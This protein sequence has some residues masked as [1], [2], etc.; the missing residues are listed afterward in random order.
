MKNNLI[1]INV[2]E[3]IPT[4]CYVALNPEFRIKLFT[5]AINRLSRKS[6]S[7]ILNVHETIIY[8][9]KIGKTKPPLDKVFRCA[10]LLNINKNEI[11]ENIL[12][13]TSGYK[14]FV[15]LND[16]KLILDEKFAEWLG[17]LVGDGCVIEKYIECDNS[18]IDVIFFFADYLKKV[19]KISKNQMKIS[20]LVPS[21]K[22]KGDGEAFQMIFKKKG[23]T[24]ILIYTPQ[25]SKLR[26]F[27]MRL[28]VSNKTLAGILFNLLP[29]LYGLISE[30][31]I[32]V[33]TAYIRGFA[34]AEGG[35][36]LSGSARKIFICQKDPKELDFVKTLLQ[37]IGIDH[38]SNPKK[39]ERAYSIFISTRKEIE[40][41]KTLIGF[42]SNK[43][44]NEK[45]SNVI[46]SYHSE[47]SYY[48]SK[49]I[50][51]E[52]IL[53]LIRREKKITA[54]TI[55]S[56]SNIS[57]KRVNELLNEMLNKNLILVSKSPKPF[58]YSLS[59]DRKLHKI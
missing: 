6:L 14:G 24:N 21:N 15:S 54:K 26:K 44:K 28:R 31:P 59:K 11:R 16:W 48:I 53:E 17:L 46:D 7:Q 20:I 10:E 2:I 25:N 39:G 47:I 19:F 42:G 50:R 56:S 9:W 52:E 4:R 1:K 43:I 58:T 34:A 57:Y 18:C 30:S 55:A 36:S 51:Y 8:D 33:K 38:V 45:L 23:F 49:K 27:A 40:K 37:N 5:E 3:Y 12:I 22:R 32:N 35:S 13:L 41:F 29:E